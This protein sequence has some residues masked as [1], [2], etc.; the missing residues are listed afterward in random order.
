PHVSPSWGLVFDECHPQQIDKENV[1]ISVSQDSC[2]LN[3]PLDFILMHANLHLQRSIESWSS[4]LRF[5]KEKKKAQ[6]DEADT[7]KASGVVTVEQGQNRFKY[8]HTCCWPACSIKSL[9]SLL[10]HCVARAC[11]NATWQNSVLA[12]R[13]AFEI[14]HALPCPYRE[15]ISTP[16]GKQTYRSL[17]MNSCGHSTTP[18]SLADHVIARC[19]ASSAFAWAAATIKNKPP[20]SSFRMIFTLQLR[21][22]IIAVLRSSRKLKLHSATTATKVARGGT[23]E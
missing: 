5:R 1:P 16:P 14:A 20:M 23:D 15:I 7:I 2:Q 17:S 19:H 13:I 10:W 22:R 8:S 12:L 9:S 21:A 18:P 6:A 11:R 4:S 3:Q